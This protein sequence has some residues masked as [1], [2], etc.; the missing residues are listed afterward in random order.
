MKKK[1]ANVYILFSECISG[2]YG[3]NCTQ[4]CGNCKK[5]TI[6]NSRSGM[7]PAGCEINLIPP[8]C[9]SMTQYIFDWKRW[10]QEPSHVFQYIN[11][12]V[13]KMS[14]WINANNAS[15]RAEFF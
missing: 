6:C 14:E 3:E 15:K 5:G 7:C 1:Y 11:A 2:F 12:K 8:Y 9:T 10:Q 4:L 13:I